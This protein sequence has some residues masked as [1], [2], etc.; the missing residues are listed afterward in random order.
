MKIYKLLSVSILILLF[1]TACQDNADIVNVYSSRHYRADE[2]VFKR[3]TEETGIEVNLVKANSDQLINRLEME[4]PLSP[5]DVLITAD[6]GRLIHAQNKGLLQPMP[7][8]NVENI[9]PSH[10][11]DKDGH[12]TGFTQRARIVVYHR[13][14]VNPAE[15][16]TYEDL[17]HPKWEGRLLV[18]SSQSHYNQTLMASMVA[19]L[20]EEEATAWAAQLVQN[21]ARQPTG[22]DRDQVKAISAGLGDIAIINTYY[23]GLL[24]HSA[25]Q[26]ER[27]VAREMGLFF[28]NQ[29]D[30]GTHVNISGIG[31]TAHAAHYDN[32]VRLIEFMLTEESQRTFTALNYEYPVHPEV[33]WP[34]LLQSWGT[35]K[36]D[37]LPLFQL[38]E[39][40]NKGLLIFNKVGWE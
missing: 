30:R 18:R 33:K 1:T 19:A 24:L 20:G 10:L 12:W 27:A 35:F 37:T 39:S 9:V 4:G 6:A 2:A 16:S 3:F 14:R 36:S 25:N 40:L 32:A 31:I 17:A 8:P 15:L 5:A 26:E 21:M 34:K 7:S 11:R 23:M 13:D 38:G 28:P 29:Q 22:N